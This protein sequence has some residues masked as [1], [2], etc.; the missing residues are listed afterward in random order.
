MGLPFAAGSRILASDLNNATQQGAWTSYPVTWTS[1]GTAPAKGSGGTLIGYYSKIGRNVTVKIMF[2][3][4][5]GTTFGTGY[6][7]WSLPFA[8]ATTGVPT[9]QIAHCGELVASSAGSAAFY[10]C[11][12]FI[13]QGTPSTVNGLVNTSGTFFGATNPIT[14]T[15]NGVQ[16]CITMTYESVS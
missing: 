11:A 15:G 9:N 16:F 1:S 10:V 12:A 3:S 7:S 14:F 13:S 4:G 8:A 5:T 6:Y 2:N